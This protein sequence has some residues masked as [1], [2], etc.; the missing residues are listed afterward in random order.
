[1]ANVQDVARFFIDLAAH[2]NKADNGDL[3][4]NLRLQKLL[5]F[6]QGWH[7]ARYGTPLFDAPVEAW[8]HGPVVPEVYHQYKKNGSQG[9]LS[10]GDIDVNVFTPTEYELLLD[11]AR[12]YA[13]YSTYAL[14]SL[15]HAANAPWSHTQRSAIIPQ[16]EIHAYFAGKEP[17]C[18]FDDILDDYPVEVL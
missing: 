10:A 16:N 13:N 5:Y 4:T 15:S 18:T 9:I 14:V 7:L 3:M 12:E 11:V 8:T 1:M 17:L 2:Q 6:A